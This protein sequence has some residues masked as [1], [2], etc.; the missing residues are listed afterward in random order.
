M[1]ASREPGRAIGTQL[2]HPKP[3]RRLL[4][5]IDAP[6]A[7]QAALLKDFVDHWY[8]ELDRPV[9]RGLGSGSYRRPYWQVQQAISKAAPTSASGVWKRSRPSRPSGS[10]I[11]CVSVT[12]AIRVTCCGRMN[13]SVQCRNL[14]LRN[15][16]HSSRCTDA[17]AYVLVASTVGKVAPDRAAA[18]AC[19]VWSV[20]S[21]GDAVGRWM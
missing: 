11:A 14:R 1:I 13:H 9:K 2:C 12:P 21:E 6:A 7:K 4:K 16:H 20:N 3:Y 5:A 10:M 18:G 8:A 17:A 19:H 15:R